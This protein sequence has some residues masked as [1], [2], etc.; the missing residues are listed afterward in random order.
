MIVITSVLESISIAAFFPVLSLLLGDSPEGL[1]GFLGFITSVS[2][3]LPF[4]NPIVSAS[5]FLI[6]LFLVKTALVLFRDILLAYAAAKVGY[7]IKKEAM[8]RYAGAQ[9]QFFLDTP[10]G[11]LIYNGISATGTVSRLLIT[12]PQMVATFLKIM[13]VAIMLL[14]IVPMAAL[15]LIAL[16]LLYYLAIHLLSRKVT[17]K[18]AIGRAEASA[19]ELVIANEFLSGIR[20]IISFNASKPWID[21]FDREN[22]TFYELHAKHSAS[23]AVPR[24]IM[25]LLAVVLMLLVVVILRVTSVDSITQV[26]PR[27][28][29]FAVAMAQL[30]PGL[31]ALGASRMALMS[32]LPNVE[33]AY[34]TIT[35]PMPQRR[36]GGDDLDSFRK[37]VAFENVSFAYK[38]REPILDNVNLT[39]EKGKVTAI[40]GPSGSGKTT[41][42]N[43]ILGLFEPTGG[44]IS[45]DGVPLQE[46]TL[47]SWL[48]KIGFVS[49][50]PFTYHTSIADNILFGRNGCSTESVIGAA[51]IANA[52]GFI[53]ELPQ[54]YDTIVGERGMKLSG[55][56][57]QRLAIARAVLDSPEILIFDEATSALDGPSEKLVQEAID[58]VS[59][60]RTAILIAHR[61]TT[62][63]H[64][65]KIIVFDKGQVVE[66]GSHQELLSKDSHYARLVG[67]SS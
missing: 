47:N 43:L 50:E 29:I 10:Q 12:G 21:R 46:L 60:D 31:A 52:H 16:G 51:K 38:G 7:Q 18:L 53:S 6:F 13:A 36:K 66:E 62:I 27:L 59:A 2:E 23:I 4:G 11:T 63:K 57:Q 25:E 28:G 37:V 48:G 40:V 65:D 32:M 58:K 22:R 41:I 55:G 20:Q 42:V 15:A 39:F 14:I 24:P 30:L 1:G 44:K 19:Q 56:Q 8:A 5:V 3:I 64:A 17:F 34:I 9:Y 26:L 49:Q 35:G 67:A 54:G 45:V 61:L 33:L